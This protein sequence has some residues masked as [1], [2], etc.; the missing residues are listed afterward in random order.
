MKQIL[1]EATQYFGKL[2][3]IVMPFIAALI[4]YV[5]MHIIGRKVGRWVYNKY[6]ELRGKK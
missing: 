2:L 1:I 3:Q 6:R 5:I 4:I